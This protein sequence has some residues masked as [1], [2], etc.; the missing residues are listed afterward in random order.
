MV[1]SSFKIVLVE[2]SGEVEIVSIFV[3]SYVIL[4]ATV[5]TYPPKS[6][7]CQEMISLKAGIGGG[8]DLSCWVP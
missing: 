1:S 2:L 8:D 7:F 4:D 5:S 6:L 3:D